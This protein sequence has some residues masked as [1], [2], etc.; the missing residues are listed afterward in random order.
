MDHHDRLARPRLRPG[1]ARPFG[2]HARAAPERTMVA[3]MAARRG[4]AVRPG[5]DVAVR[6]LPEPVFLPRRLA[7]RRGAV[8]CEPQTAGAEARISVVAERLL[9]HV[10]GIDHA[11]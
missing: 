6:L 3:T 11:A 8:L 5:T 7:G 4:A 10:A 9:G 2:A 1:H